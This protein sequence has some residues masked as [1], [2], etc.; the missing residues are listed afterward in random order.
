MAVALVLAA[1]GMGRRFRQ[2]RV[3]WVWLVLAPAT[4]A[5]LAQALQLGWVHPWTVPDVAA[6]GVVSTAWSIDQDA[7]WRVMAWSVALAGFALVL[8]CHFR[9]ERARALGVTLVVVAIAHAAT[10]VLLALIGVDWPVASGAF[11][12]RGAFVYPNHA[13][14]FSACC[15]PLAILV[16]RERGGHWWWIGVGVLALAV[17]LSASRGGILV[18]S[19]IN[20]PLAWRVL[21]RKRRV[22]WFAAL[23]V[24]IGSYLA[25]IGLREVG[26]KFGKLFG[27]EGVTLNGRITIW[28]N[29][30]PLIADASPFGCGAGTAE[31][32]YWRTGDASFAGHPVNHIHSDPL[33][34]LLEFGWAGAACIAAGLMAFAWRLRP[35]QHPIAG[36]APGAT[37]ARAPADALLFWGG[38]LGLLQLLLHCCGEF[39]WNREA[40]ALA[41]IVLAILAS[42]GRADH[43]AIEPRTSTRL[44]GAFL[45]LACALAAV[46]PRAWRDD[47]EDKLAH[48]AGEFIEQRHRAGTSVSGVVIDELFS[49]RPSTT[50]LAVVQA[51]AALDLP[52]TASERAVR[53]EQ[54]RQA[55]SV[56][57]SVSP[58]D[59]GA[60]VERARMA[61]FAAR[62][63]E[64]AD[65]ALSVA[66]A[67]VMVWA[68]A[69][70]YAQVKVLDC[71]RRGGMGMLPPDEL[72]ALVRRLL[73]ID[74]P[75]PGWFFICA[76]QV[77][78]RVELEEALAKAGDRLASSGLWWL[79]Q[80]A[81]SERWLARYIELA[82]PTLVLDPSRALLAPLLGAE[83]G[84]TQGVPQRV[85]G[86][87]V[88]IRAGGDME[89]R[90]AQS[91]ELQAAGLP[92]P[93]ELSAAL[94]RDGAPWNLWATSFDPLDAAARERVRQGLS[95]DLYRPW[96]RSW[97][98]RL[99]LVDEALAGRT[100]GV[101]MDSDPALTERLVTTDMARTAGE[102]TRLGELL[103]ARARPEWRRIGP[104]CSWTWLWLDEGPSRL[105]AR[106]P[107]WRGLVVDGTWRGWLRGEISSAGIASGLHRVA[108]LD[109]P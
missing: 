39:I 20:L 11:I 35:P 17:V 109:V 62:G 104:G 53:L 36:A 63:D 37:G 67:R 46:I 2:P 82:P 91:D 76:Q 89:S 81:S 99:A 40:I 64:H 26:D 86:V 66:I 29:S 44:R 33:E 87:I 31:Q 54:G 32:A 8:H 34:W 61:A 71:L 50:R 22:L 83:L 97:F 98:D 38:T 88:E 1:V 12:A 101:T 57:A 43:R 52:G 74:Q 27:P 103:R 16:A 41:A 3:G 47:G 25:V 23:L 106:T 30:L 49:A 78:G 28:K 70:P 55:L 90:R 24:G 21:P 7:S 100:L 13:A 5:A 93:P 77:L 42:E 108:L 65:R 58:G 45:L 69:W 60:W 56:A 9:G 10:A 68:P 84:P 96:A 14:A 51:R 4:L 19:A 72:R 107:V 73:A 95:A 94:V 102:R 6:L 48:D 18:A 79:A 15:L 85:A 59:A 105:I 75:Q 80:H 92:L